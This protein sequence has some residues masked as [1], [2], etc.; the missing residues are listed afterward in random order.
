MGTCPAGIEAVY[1]TFWME[2]AIAPWLYIWLTPKL[3]WYLFVIRASDAV[4]S[5]FDIWF[6]CHQKVL[7][8]SEGTRSYRS[9]PLISKIF[10]K[11]DGITSPNNEEVPCKS[12]GQSD[13]KM[14]Y[15]KDPYSVFSTSSLVDGSGLQTHSCDPMHTLQYSGYTLS[16]IYI[17]AC[18]RGGVSEE[19]RWLQAATRHGLLP[20]YTPRIL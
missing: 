9:W 8:T 3:I 5:I 18:Q 11:E 16:G 14:D 7:K 6:F 13:K 1:F 20:L 4:L 17:V 19:P 12:W 10:K 15:L 2:E